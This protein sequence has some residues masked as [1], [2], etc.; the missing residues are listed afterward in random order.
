LIETHRDLV[1]KGKFLAFAPG[2]EIVH[3]H[4]RSVRDRSPRNRVPRDRY[5]L[6]IDGHGP[7]MRRYAQIIAIFQKDHGIMRIAQCHGDLHNSVEHRL[8]VGR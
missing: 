6:K 2:C 1:P 4:R 5:A 8:Y 3:V 7:V